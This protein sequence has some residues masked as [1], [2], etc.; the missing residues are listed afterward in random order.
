MNNEED[1]SFPTC[2]FQLRARGGTHLD[3]TPF[4]LRATHTHTRTPSGWDRVDTPAPLTRTPLG[5]ARTA[6]SRG[7][8]TQTGA[9]PAIFF[10]SLINIMTK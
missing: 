4:Q 7:K 2:F 9:R 10:F 1:H 6:V 8:P 3:G 5:C